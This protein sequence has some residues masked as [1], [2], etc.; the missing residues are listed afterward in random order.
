MTAINHSNLNKSRDRYLRKLER[1]SR[2]LKREM[3]FM[4]TCFINTGLTW[5]FGFLVALPT[6]EISIYIRFIFGLIFCVLNS[7]Q[8]LHIFIIYFLISKRRQELLKEKIM[9]QVKELKKKMKKEKMREQKRLQKQFDIDMVMSKIMTTGDKLT[10]SSSQQGTSTNADKEIV[11]NYSTTK[12]Y[13]E[14]VAT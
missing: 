9:F 7:T 3:S 12:A 5:L 4:L 11:P 10:S 13:F 1:K 8:G 14:V 2:G 6:N